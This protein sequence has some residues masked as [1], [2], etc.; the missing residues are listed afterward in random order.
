M[1]RKTVKTLAVAL[2]ALVGLGALVVG[3]LVRYV[4][5]ALGGFD[6]R[7]FEA[8]VEEIRR[9]PLRPGE[10]AA[11]R[12]D[13]KAPGSVHLVEAEEELVR[14]GGAGRVWAARSKEGHLKVVIE[15]RDLGH[16]GE[17]GYAYSDAPLKLAP[18]DANWSTVDVPGRL[19]IVGPDAR[20]D[21]HW[22]AV[23]YNLD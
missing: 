20:I 21:E 1:Q 19:N 14:G 11:L 3:V 8:V 7:R 10:E 13:P 17:Y 4:L 23:L 6:R 15:T 18:L 2:V 22:W 5:P 9:R 12:L 16:A